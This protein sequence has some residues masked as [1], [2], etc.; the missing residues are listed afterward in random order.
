MP[1]STLQKGKTW[2]SEGISSEEAVT[3]WQ[4]Y[5]AERRESP[6]D[7]SLHG[8]GEFDAQLVSHGV[9]QLR[10]LYLLAPAQKVVHRQIEQ[11]LV[12]ADHLFHL[13]YAIRGAI[14]GSAEGIRFSVKPGE[15]VLIDN[16]N[17]FELD[18][19]TPHEAVDLIMPLPW[20]EQ[21]LPDP[22]SHIGRPV[23]MDR[24]WAPPLASM[25]LTIARENDSCPLPRTL[26]A[27][28]IGH[29]V[30]LALGVKEPVAVR[31]GTRLAQ[32]IMRRI[33]GDFADPELSPEGVAADLRISKRYLQTL[34]A[35]SG[36]SFVRELNAVRLDKASNML[37]DPASRL[38]PV[39]EV[40]YRCGFLDPGY[41]ARQFRKRFN[42]TPRAWRE[43][44]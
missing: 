6:V 18:M 38:L 21:F 35:N 17:R 24:G 37:T 10:L 4:S 9:G 42:A 32:Q 29:L 5:F 16:S 2:S 22:R 13:I 39:A 20:L 1:D 25:L 28:Q 41:F 36:T 23:P 8:S 40:A 11:D 15:F 3:R 31:P 27:E 34:L 30:A 7:I 14:R 12:A 44:A 19:R 43:M 26:V 33:E